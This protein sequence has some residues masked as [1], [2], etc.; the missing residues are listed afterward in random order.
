[1]KAKCLFF[2]VFFSL[3]LSGFS[4]DITKDELRSFY[5]VL[6]EKTD[7]AIRA[8]NNDLVTILENTY[9]IVRA[10]PINDSL[11]TNDADNYFKVIQLNKKNTELFP[12][13]VVRLDEKP[14]Q[15]EEA[16]YVVMHM[17]VD[18]T[19]LDSVNVLK[20]RRSMINEFSAYLTEF[21]RRNY[22]VMNEDY[23]ALLKIDRQIKAILDKNSLLIAKPDIQNKVK[24]VKP[25]RF[26][27]FQ[28]NPAFKNQILK[29]QE[30]LK[31]QKK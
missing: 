21:N 25:D 31:Q 5:R 28:S 12:P 20:P 9:R 26:K 7:K 17:K 16:S 8:G 19:L 2:I 13:Y 30:I 23:Q 15:M 11:E 24:I 29:Q 10:L 4:Q 18:S 3:S 6:L 1:M 27:K 22:I 14:E